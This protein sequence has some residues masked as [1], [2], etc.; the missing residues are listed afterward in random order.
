MKEEKAYKLL[1]LQENISNSEAKEL[2]DAGLVSARGAKVSIARS[3]MGVTTKFSV[4]KMPKPSVI[5]QDKNLIAINKPAFLT[6]EK[7]AEIYKFPLLHRLDRET[8]GV[9]ILVKNDEF[10]NKAIGEFKKMNVKKEYLAIVKGILSEEITINQPII[11]LKNK[12]GALSKISQ[13]GKE[14]ISY[15]TPVMVSGKKSLVKVEIKTGRTHQIR[16][17]LNSIGYPIIGDEKYGKNTAARM[18]LHAYKIDLLEYKF[19][20]EL[21]NDFNSLGFEISRNFDI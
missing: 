8:S 9:L 10:K 12:G 17:H 11:T 5:F 14:A 7:I 20:A 2:I 16:V 15:V 21:S 1:A 13:N 18:F 6:S 4:A 3:M 19:K